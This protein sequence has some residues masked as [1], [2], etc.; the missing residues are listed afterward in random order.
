[1]TPHPIS[2]GSAISTGLEQAFDRFASASGHLIDTYLALQQ[3]VAHL[4]NQLEAAHQQLSLQGAENTSLLNRLSLLLGML[5]A[6]VLELDP[7]GLISRQNAAA[8]SLLGADWVGRP[9]ANCFPVFQAD[10]GQDCFLYLHPD[11]SPR[12]VLLQQQ[13]LPESA[14]T[15]V[16]VQDITRSRAMQ[17]TL[18]SQERL[19][20]MGRMAASLAHQLRTPLTTAML[21]TSHLT[22]D[23]LSESD[24]KRFASKS[25]ARLQALE[26][27]VADM[28]EFVRGDAPDPVWL[29]VPELLAETFQEFEPHVSTHALRLIWPSTAPKAWVKGEHRAFVGAWLNLLENALVF[30]PPHSAL[31]VSAVFADDCF[32]FSVADQGAGV[33]KEHLERIFDPF[34]TT[35]PE[36]TGLGLAIARRVA[37]SAGGTLT[38]DNGTVGACFRMRL[39]AVTR[40]P[41]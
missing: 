6:G 16:V 13:P 23:F 29:S 34:Y 12:H 28:L 41:Y 27:R 21:Y 33:P 20:S 35:R 14:G 25:L 17:D 37:E 30:A 39:P 8:Q 31:I 9:W 15:I 1:M 5:P 4:S 38:L 3:Q 36:G 10:A 7:D 40:P 19:A 18:A 26:A 24:R 32:L 22:R 11:G 2:G